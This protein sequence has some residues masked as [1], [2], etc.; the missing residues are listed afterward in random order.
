MALKIEQVITAVKDIAPDLKELLCRQELITD[1][2]VKVDAV[3]EH[4]L[5]V[6]AVIL[7]QY[8]I[9]FR[10]LGDRKNELPLYVIR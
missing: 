8:Y 3:L 6:L 9:A 2:P 1:I 7:K 5:T 10:V 4:L